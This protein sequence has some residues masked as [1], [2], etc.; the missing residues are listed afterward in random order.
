MHDFIMREGKILFE[1]VKLKQ[2]LHYTHTHTQH[3]SFMHAI[4]EEKINALFRKMMHEYIYSCMILLCGR[5]K[6]YFSLLN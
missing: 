2:S 4:H 6:F 5:G 3:G 1:S